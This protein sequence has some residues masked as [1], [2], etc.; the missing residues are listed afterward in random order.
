MPMSSKTGS[1]G[2]TAGQ[3]QLGEKSFLR[4]TLDHL[5]CWSLPFL[6][7]KLKYSPTNDTNDAYLKFDH[8]IMVEGS[9]RKF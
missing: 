8:T 3:T 2:K 6:T 7:P 9:S 4:E 1:A 5:R